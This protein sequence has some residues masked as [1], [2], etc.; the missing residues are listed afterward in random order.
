[1][2]IKRKDGKP[3]RMIIAR[4]GPYTYKWGTEHKTA[5]ELKRM[6]AMTPT[7]KLTM[8]HPIKG[9]TKRSDFLGY[10][11]PLYNDEI[12]AVVGEVWPYREHWYKV[13][14]AI[15]DKIV[16]GEK[17]KTSAGFNAEKVEDD[18]QKDMFID[19][20]AILREGAHP[21]C[22]L[23]KCGINVRQESEDMQ[24]EEPETTI[25]YEQQSEQSDDDFTEDSEP[26]EDMAV[27]V[28]PLIDPP[29]KEKVEPTVEGLQAEI[30]TLNEVI[31]GF[32]QKQEA[33][34]SEQKTEV[35]EE[36][37][38]VELPPPIPETVI[39]SGVAKRPKEIHI[40]E[41]GNAVIIHQPK[42][43]K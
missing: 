10:V 40:D 32:Q 4:P 37:E 29:E 19:H 5:E 22:P 42:K 23:D 9:V 41:S 27:G 20:V 25:Y 18:V 38:V 36:K 24:D 1:M 13:P 16:N 14:E 3:I 21:T 34:P 7:I 2:A 11:K 43:S 26:V 15:Q 28:I 8:G 17:W 30:E 35:S 33:E 6:I 31:A 12:D 39:Q